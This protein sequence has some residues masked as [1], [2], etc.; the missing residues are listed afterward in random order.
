MYPIYFKAALKTIDDQVLER[1]YASISLE[2]RSVDFKS[3]FVPLM[4]MGSPVKIV[5]LA[6]DLETHTFV[7]EVYLS[8]PQ[9]LRIVSV[10]EAELSSAAQDIAEQRSAAH[11]QLEITVSIPAR[12]VPVRSNFEAAHFPHP[13]KTWIDAEIY[14]ISADTIKFSCLRPFLTGQKLLVH[15]DEPLVIRKMVLDVYQALMFGDDVTGHLCTID[16]LPQP[17]SE[18]LARYIEQVNRS[19]R[20]FTDEPADED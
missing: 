11:K 5:Q 14:S 7:G 9:L 18:N 1:G 17:Y 10:S 8:A 16:A 19:N 15:V 2:T 3:E 12:L 6:G 20:I 4:K 13:R